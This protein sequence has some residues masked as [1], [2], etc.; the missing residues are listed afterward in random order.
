MMS[1]SPVED[2]EHGEKAGEDGDR[3]DEVLHGVPLE[4]R[5]N[6]VTGDIEEREVGRGHHR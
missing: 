1:Y 5:P 6:A 3:K 4:S 2:E